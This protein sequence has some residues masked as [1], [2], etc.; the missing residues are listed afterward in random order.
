MKTKLPPCSPAILTLGLCLFLLPAAQAQRMP[1]DSWY[2]KKTTEIGVPVSAIA[3]D[4]DGNIYV[5]DPEG[6]TIKKYTPSYELLES[7]GGW[8]SGDGQFGQ[9]SSATSSRP[10][11]YLVED[12]TGDISPGLHVGGGTLDIVKMETVETESDIIF[13]LTVNGDIRSPDWGL[14]MVAI[15]NQALPGTTNGNAWGRP[16]S[17]NAGN[18]QGMTHWIGSWVNGG[19]GSQFFSYDG[20]GWNQ[21]ESPGLSITAGERSTITYSVSKALLGLSDGDT[22]VF[23]AYSSAGGGGDSA[24]DA[25]SNPDI[26]VTSWGGP[27]TSESPNLSSLGLEQQDTGPQ[28]LC[29]DAAQN[30]IACDPVNHRVQV[31]S[32]AGEFLLKFGTEGSGNGQFSSPVAAVVSADNKIYVADRDNH[33]IQVFDAEGNFVS[34][35]G[36][37]GS[38]DGQLIRPTGLA[39]LPDGKVAVADSGNRRIQLFSPDGEYDRKLTGKS[40]QGLSAWRNGTILS[41]AAGRTVA[42]AGD[43]SWTKELSFASSSSRA[44]VAVALP[45]GDAL[46]A[47]DSGAIQHFARTFRTILPE[48]ANAVPM[49]VVL[50]T[51]QRPGSGLVD[52]D[53]RVDDAD[54]A[55]VTTAVVAFR[56]GGASLGDV[57]PIRTFAEG[58]ETNLGAGMATGRNHRFTWDAR[59]DLAGDF[60]QV[61]VEV[62]VRDGRD[63]FNVDFIQIPEGSGEPSL[64]ISKTPLKDS[65]FFSAMLWLI[66]SGDPEISF[67]DGKVTRVSDGSD[68]GLSSKWWAFKINKIRGSRWGGNDA[69][70]LSEFS[71]FQGASIV[72]MAGVQVTNPGFNNGNPSEEPS[73]AADSNDDTK[74]LDYSFV[75]GERLIF[76]FPSPV[77]FDSYRFITGGD[78]EK[79][80]PVSWELQVSSDGQNWSTIDT[81][82]DASVP[83]ERRALTESYL[84]DGAISA[85]VDFLLARMGLRAA[86]PAEILRAKEAGTPGVINQWDPPLQVGPGERP[87]K[88]NAYGFETADTGVWVVPTTP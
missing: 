39:I 57:I 17:L 58:T 66:A 10:E 3:Q 71:F 54:N 64:K 82:V 31:F 50:S 73:S 38:F 2:L 78:A 86:T 37:Q 70:Q 53:Y 63:L 41:V 69:V 88:V 85:G 60:E 55:A 44:L 32:R 1:Q 56:N 18:G 8:G 75:P 52:V 34:H 12:A 29:F 15:A 11:F 19:G 35:F 36:E 72:P 84:I 24:I 76:E 49:P 28:G 40:A 68:L 22:I 80:D 87:V 45:N 9:Q 13:T 16:I 48:A 77:S 5:S 27:Y 74:W 51:A 59:A 42:I 67:A 14:F 23:D 4:V 20:A 62:L 7:W 33:R 47:T 61:R 43:D 25:L 26:T 79:R 6:G 46:V 21:L 83:F 65:D 30:L 81:K